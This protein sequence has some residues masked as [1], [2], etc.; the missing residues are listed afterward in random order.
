M[1]EFIY[2]ISD[3]TEI[4]LPVCLVIPKS[5]PDLTKATLTSIGATPPI[6]EF[7]NISKNSDNSYKISLFSNDLLIAGN[8]YQFK[9]N[10]DDPGAQVNQPKFPEFIV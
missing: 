2:Y 10:F 3:L 1:N 4:N 5:L 6:A 8:V 7:A 9:L